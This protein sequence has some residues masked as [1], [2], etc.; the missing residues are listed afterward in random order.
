M[1][2]LNTA[3]ETGTQLTAAGIHCLLR[4][5]K[6]LVLSVFV[7]LLGAASVFVMLLPDMYE[8]ELKLIIKRAR[9][10]V[11]VDVDKGGASLLATDVTDREIASEIE[12]FCN[13]S[14]LEQTVVARGLAEEVEDDVS[15]RRTRVALAVRELERRL[16]VA[17]ISNTS[18]ISARYSHADSNRAAEV[19]RTLT[20][21]Y[22]AKHMAVHR[23]RD[24]SGFFSEQTSLYKEQ[25]TGAQES[26]A[27]FRRRHEVSLLAAEKEAALRRENELETALQ[28]TDSQI[29]DAGDRLTL[30]RRQH[31]ELPAT[32]ETESRS[33]RNEALL[34]RLKTALLDL[35]NK[36]TELLTKYDGSYR[37]VREVEEQ[38]RD[39]RAMIRNEQQAR[40]V[41]TTRAVNPLRQSIEGELLRV[42]ASISGLEAKRQQLAR[43][44]QKIRTKQLEL[45]GITAE[46]DDLVRQ[47]KLTEENYLL[48]QRKW[49]ESRL[50]D[51]MDAVR[52]LN[53]SV[54]E[55]A[56]PPAVPA[57]QHKAFL[58]ILATVLAGFGTLGL[59]LVV[60]HNLPS[61]SRRA[62]TQETAVT[63][64]P[65]TAVEQA[66]GRRMPEQEPVWS[67][68]PIFAAEASAE[69]A[70]VPVDEWEPEPGSQPGAGNAEYPATQ[71]LPVLRLQAGVVEM[72]S[73]D[74]V[75]RDEYGHVIE[76]LIAFHGPS[77]GVAI[78]LA[79][80]IDPEEAAVA[81]TQLAHSMNRRNRLPVLLVDGSGATDSLAQL[82]GAADR[83]GLRDLLLGSSGIENQCIHRTSFE[84]LWILPGGDRPANGKAPPARVNA[85]H[86]ALA[87]R[88][89]NLIIHLPRAGNGEPTLM[90]YSVLDAV[91]S[92]LKAEETP[93]RESEH[94]VRRVMEAKRS[95]SMCR[96]T[97]VGGVKEW[98][99]AD[100]H[101]LTIC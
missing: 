10:E 34:E 36:R 79:P 64:A 11:P 22:V 30:L 69:D 57:D 67:P 66:G 97:L 4:R 20:N 29:Q 32:I 8:A 65:D 89:L 25:L 6:R 101:A 59:A 54:V 73:R 49:E 63:P 45:D 9:T 27:A 75:R 33:A 41:G 68:S 12:L 18:L 55:E 42:E 96:V 62:R 93:G 35:E 84:N 56:T 31:R 92:N 46:H 48:Y 87:N 17:R 51:A 52:I 15:D 14:S 16:R 23:S 95:Y 77:E 1:Q 50:A 78:G 98:G 61:H 74:L 19:L 60:D 76:Y 5:R 39:T 86:K 81:A 43:D 44:L 82:F 13:R 37:L 85:L 21:T 47:V 28:E 70:S 38:I 100:K 53:V 99:E 7:V 3:G 90:L 91:I 58:M 83:P 80:E 24:T 88:S 72:M 26:L 40:V 71:K 2:E 94:I